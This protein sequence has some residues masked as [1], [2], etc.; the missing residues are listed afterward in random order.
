MKKSIIFGFLCLILLNVYAGKKDSQAWKT[1]K[2]LESQFTSLKAN[3]SYWDGFF[4][5]KE[6]Q[7]NEF[8]QATM[9]T[10]VG[11]ENNIATNK[12]EISKLKN[13]IEGLSKEL[14]ETETN[15][16]DSQSKENLLQTLGIPFDKSIFPPL[17]YGIITL[18][19][20]VVAVAFFLFF[21]SNVITKETKKRYNELSDEFDSQ[22]KLALERQ[23]KLNRELQTERNKNA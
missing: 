17:M 3:A 19:A 13:K 12:V 11:L 2:Q 5:F 14:S 16:A 15:L 21:R 6:A 10:V 22:K 18:L 7:L 20:L 9:D 23:T 8:H 1:E 4:M